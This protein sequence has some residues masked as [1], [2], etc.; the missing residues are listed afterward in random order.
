MGGITIEIIY[1]IALRVADMIK[2]FS[3]EEYPELYK[4]TARGFLIDVEKVRN[5]VEKQHH[6]RNV[7]FWMGEN[8]EGDYN[9]NISD[10]MIDRIIIGIKLYS[11]GTDS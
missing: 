1:G 2:L 8:S 7:G 4:E 11:S 3:H 6:Y 9:D 5:K 10:E